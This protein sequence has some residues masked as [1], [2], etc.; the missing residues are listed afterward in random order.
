MYTLRRSNDG[1]G[2]LYGPMNRRV[3]ASFAPKRHAFAI[4][5]READ[6]RGFTTDSGKV[7]QIVTHGD[8]DLAT[9]GK[10]FFPEALHTVDVM[11]VIE[12]LYTAGECFYREG[13]AELA[14]WIEAQKE[15]LYGGQEAVIV[16]DLQRRLAGVPPTGP[17]KRDG[18][19]GSPRPSII[20]RSGCPR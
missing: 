8:D 17:G 20:S 12:Y 15:R 16:E 9:Y 7:V 2:R 18:A 13:S 11:H 1:T 4:A 6:K 3:Y 5:R 19:N 10:E 14:D